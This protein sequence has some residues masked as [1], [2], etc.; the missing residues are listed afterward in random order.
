[1]L[2]GGADQVMSSLSNALVVFAIA[3]STSVADFGHAALM[4]SIVAAAI[5]VSRGAIGTPLLLMG[6]ANPDDIRLEARSAAGAAAVFGAV[7][8]VVIAGASIAVHASGIGIAFAVSVPLVLAQDA[9]RFAAIT[10]GQPESALWSDTA[11]AVGSVGLLGITWLTPA[12]PSGAFMT[13]GWAFAAGVAL[14]L[15]AA[16]LRLTPTWRGLRGWWRPDHRMRVRYGI[17]SGIEQLTVITVVSLTTGIVGPVAAAALRG[18]ITILGPFAILLNTLTLVAIP[19]ASRA[20]YR[21]DQLWRK[22][23]LVALPASVAALVIGF[24]TRLVPTRIGALILGD[25]WTAA[26]KVLPILGVEYSAL[27]WVAAAF[28]LFRYRRN[29]RLLIA[30]R[31]TQSALTVVLCICFGAIFPT[32]VGVAGALASAAI[33]TALI[34]TTTA[35]GQVSAVRPRPTPPASGNPVSPRRRISSR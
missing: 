14:V 1:M 6:G 7:V 8:G 32:A 34:L 17:D 18:A 12:R 19:E 9:L 13:W 28:S 16:R 29:T 2:T 26:A 22:L 15:L 23:S 4:F 24:G 11:W 27:C 3:R 21:I 35:H 10:L 30:A 5:G 25:S 31:M 33:L 20:G